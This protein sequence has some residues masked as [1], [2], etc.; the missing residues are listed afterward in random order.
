[1][2]HI[3]ISAGTNG[4]KTTVSEMR[5]RLARVLSKLNGAQEVSFSF[6]ASLEH[7]LPAH[8]MTKSAAL[9]APYGLKPSASTRADRLAAR[10][11]TNPKACS[12]CLIGID[13]DGDGNCG[14]CAKH[15]DAEIR[16][17]LWGYAANEND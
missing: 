13:H 8:Q 5:K 14:V 2:A 6:A 7:Y 9:G 11:A 15:N 12:R 1:M 3:T 4:E 16:S 17:G 10:R